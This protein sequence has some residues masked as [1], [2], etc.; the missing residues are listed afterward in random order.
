M[1]KMISWVYGPAVKKWSPRVKIGQMCGDS[2]SKIYTPESKEH[3]HTV[4][5]LVKND[6][7]M[8]EDGSWTIYAPESE[9]HVQTVISSLPGRMFVDLIVGEDDF[10]ECD[11]KE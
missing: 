11:Y 9:E 1:D 6:H 4:G 8:N 10:S 5:S 2:G 7:Q 3:V